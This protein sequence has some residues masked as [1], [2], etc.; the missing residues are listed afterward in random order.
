MVNVLLIVL[1][2]LDLILLGVVYFLGKQ[3]LNPREI[4]LEMNEERRLIKELRQLVKE[5]LEEAQALI[6]K[7]TEKMAII[8]TWTPKDPFK[9]M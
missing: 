5:E 3:R 4:L 7:E 8:A 2:A 9:T 1:A 6:K